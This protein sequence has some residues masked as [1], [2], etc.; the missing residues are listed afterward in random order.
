MILALCAFVFELSHE[1][2]AFPWGGAYRLKI[3][4]TLSESVC[5]ASMKC[6]LIIVNNWQN[7]SI[8]QSQ[9]D[10]GS[11]DQTI[12]EGVLIVSNW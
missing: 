2:D 4:S 1:P 5:T 9:K 11:I 8:L 6:I 7:P 12:Y 10:I 3:I